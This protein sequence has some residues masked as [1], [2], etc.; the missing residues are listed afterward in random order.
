MSILTILRGGDL[1][2]YY[3]QILDQL[4][5]IYHTHPTSLQYTTYEDIKQDAPSGYDEIAHA[6][7][8]DFQSSGHTPLGKLIL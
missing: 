1:E 5:A 6:S 4:D 7:N 8:A 2:N 3:Y